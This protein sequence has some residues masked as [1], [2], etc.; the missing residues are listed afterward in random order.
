MRA[1]VCLI[2]VVAFMWSTQAHPYEAIYEPGQG[3]TTFR[4]AAFLDPSLWKTSGIDSATGQPRQALTRAIS[5]WLAV[6]VGLPETDDLPAVS[7]ASP[8]RMVA[9]RHRDIPSER[10]GSAPAAQGDIL[11]I[12]D[13]EA[14]TIYLPQTWTGE[15]PAE[16][17]VLVHEMVHHIQNAAGLSYACPEAREELAYLA[18]ERWL[19]M[20]GSDLM[21]EFQLDPMTLLVRTH[22]GF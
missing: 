15:T 11:A 14:R 19:A 20:F 5:T 17:S 18:Q 16:I 7:L 4:P 13:D 10:W 2:W 1:R 6:D 9:L 12:Y 21:T 8:Q 3:A 22:C